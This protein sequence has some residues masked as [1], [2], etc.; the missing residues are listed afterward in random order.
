MK[1][2]TASALALLLAAGVLALASPAAAQAPGDPS[3]APAKGCTAKTAKVADA[4]EVGARPDDFAGQCVKLE[5]WW[6]D[7]AFYPTRSE[8]AVIDALSLVLLDE[9]RVGLYLSP[10]DL[11]AAPQGPKLASVVG[12]VGG[13]CSRLPATVT[14]ADAGYCHYKPGAY[15]AVSAISLAK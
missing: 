6:R 12:T 15:L 4:G 2:H 14:T 13:K 5:G 7:I 9:R 1:H 8:A 10:K 3:F 11:A